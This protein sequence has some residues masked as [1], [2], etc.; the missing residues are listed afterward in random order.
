MIFSPP[1][2]FAEQKTNKYCEIDLNESNWAAWEKCEGKLVKITGK[3]AGLALQHPVGMHDTLDFKTGEVKGKYE[4]R[5]DTGGSQIVITSDQKTECSG[6]I[7]VEGIV[8][9]VDLGGEEGSKSGYKNVWI[10]VQSY[11][12]K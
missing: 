8:D 6:D 9:I 11:K 10:R 7:T 12:C 3:I 4:T 1:A 5:I 2:V